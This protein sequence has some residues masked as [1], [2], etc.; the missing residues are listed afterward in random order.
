M[1]E[2]VVEMGVREVYYEQRCGICSS[3][4]GLIPFRSKAICPEC[5]NFIRTLEVCESEQ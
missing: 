4:S 2:I 5:L 3:S 1:T